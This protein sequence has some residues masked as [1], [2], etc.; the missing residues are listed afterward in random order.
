MISRISEACGILLLGMALGGWFVYW[1]QPLAFDPA[2]HF[3]REEAQQVYF[4]GYQTKC[5]GKIYQ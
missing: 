3:T 2:N 4:L 1:S 5:G